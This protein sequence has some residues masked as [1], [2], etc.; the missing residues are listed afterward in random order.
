MRECALPPA[1]GGEASILR[2]RSYLA[3]VAVSRPQLTAIGQSSGIAAGASERSKRV[4]RAKAVAVDGLRWEET[5]RVMPR[6]SGVLKGS[7]NVVVNEQ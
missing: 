6:H 7:L 3:I 1:L 2:L 4:Q 5:R